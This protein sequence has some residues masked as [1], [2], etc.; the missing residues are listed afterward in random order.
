VLLNEPKLRKALLEDGP[1]VSYQGAIFVLFCV[2]DLL[3]EVRRLDCTPSTKDFIRFFPRIAVDHLG[4]LTVEGL[5]M[6]G[7]LD[8]KILGETLFFWT[9]TEILKPS[10]QDSITDFEDQKSNLMQKISYQIEKVYKPSI[11]ERIKGNYVK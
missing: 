10:E 9:R 4:I 2:D 3:E 5:K 7:L 8:W 1:K 6:W 11:L